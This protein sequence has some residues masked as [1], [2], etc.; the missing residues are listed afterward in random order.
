MKKLCVC[1]AIAAAVA[2]VCPRAEAKD[3]G[4]Y[5]TAQGGVQ[6]Q[7]ATGPQFGFEAGGHVLLFDGYLGAMFYGSSRSVLRAILGVRGALG[8]GAV[9]LV[10]RGGLGL[11]HE[12]NGALSTSV[13][14]VALTRTG[15]LLRGGAAFEVRLYRTFW[16]GVGL[17]GEAYTFWGNNLG[18]PAHSTNVLGVLKLTWELP[19]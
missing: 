2:T 16:A 15:G 3:S 1:L 10:L 13:G 4:V 8:R 5:A 6:T 14:D 11:A 9:R 12:Q 19:L 17:D 18:F 7:G